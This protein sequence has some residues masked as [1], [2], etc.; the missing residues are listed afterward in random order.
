MVGFIFAKDVVVGMTAFERD[1]FPVDILA[2]T[3]KAKTVELSLRAQGG[4]LQTEPSLRRFKPTTQLLVDIPDTM[5]L[6]Q[7]FKAY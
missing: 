3:D 4:M 5:E 6:P 7:S 2:K 1:G